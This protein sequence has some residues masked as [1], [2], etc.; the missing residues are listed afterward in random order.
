MAHNAMHH[1]G[2]SSR[3]CPN[4]NFNSCFLLVD[5]LCIFICYL[6]DTHQYSG[7]TAMKFPPTLS[8]SKT[9]R[10][11]TDRLTPNKLAPV[12]P[13]M[14]GLATP[15]FLS[16]CTFPTRI[17]KLRSRLP[18]QSPRLVMVI[19]PTRLVLP[20]STR[21]HG[22][23]SSLV[24]MHDPPL[25]IGFALPGIKWRGIDYGAGERYSKGL[26]QHSDYTIHGAQFLNSR[27]EF[28]KRGHTWCQRHSSKEPCP[29]CVN[30]ICIQSQVGESKR[31]D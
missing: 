13:G 15:P 7:L 31:F 21:H 24:C 16:S 29:L 17:S 4:S 26:W 9:Y 3:C 25:H 27:L 1:F 28:R 19:V 20:K 2:E 18:Q 12:D 23:V 14:V 30:N 8:A 22:L 5:L 11:Q 6:W 10:Y